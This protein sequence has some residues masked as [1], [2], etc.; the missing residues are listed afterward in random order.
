MI[1]NVVMNC[2]KSGEQKADSS[3]PS[4]LLNHKSKLIY[5][6]EKRDSIY[7]NSLYIYIYSWTLVVPISI[8]F[9]N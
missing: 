3:F 8:Y 5:V 6:V 2:L 4:S 9:G 7:I 1:I